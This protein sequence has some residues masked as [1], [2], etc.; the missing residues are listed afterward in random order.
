MDSS[1][2]VFIGL[3]VLSELLPFVK[4]TKGSGVLHSVLCIVQGSQCVLSKIEEQVEKELK[5]EA[6]V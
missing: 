5:K 3:F 1:T 2:Y 6:V 4:K